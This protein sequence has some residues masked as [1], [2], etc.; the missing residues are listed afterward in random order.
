MILSLGHRYCEHHSNVY[1]SPLFSLQHHFE[2]ELKWKRSIPVRP[3]MRTLRIFCLRQADT[4]TATT[5]CPEQR[6]NAVLPQNSTTANQWF[7]QLLLPQALFLLVPL[8]YYL[9][10]SQRNPLLQMELLLYRNCHHPH[11]PP[12]YRNLKGKV[13]I[14]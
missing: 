9:V 8:L 7:C 14:I 11:P 10:T 6:L 3:V 5:D 2:R 4:M 13:C 12:Q 1:V